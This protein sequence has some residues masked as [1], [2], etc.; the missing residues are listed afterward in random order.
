MGANLQPAHP[1][2]RILLTFLPCILTAQII[3]EPAHIQVFQTTAK[4]VHRGATVT[5]RWSATGAEQVRLEPLGLVLPAKGEITH[6]VTSRIVYWLHVT[7]GVGGQSVPLVVDLLPDEPALAVPAVPPVAPPDWPRLADLSP[8]PPSQAPALPP[9]PARRLARRRGPR[10]VWIQ[11]AATVSTKGAAKLKR[12]LKRLAATDSTLLVR[13][14][15]TGRP[16]QL[17]RSGPFHSLQAARL[18]LQEL[19]PAMQ[20]MKIKPIIIFGPPQPV[21][22]ETTYLADSRQPG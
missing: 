12:N 4:A 19:A 14:R 13:N 17:I 3:P 1:M 20:A 16:F 15:R 8:V 21:A 9:P 6:R 5:L 22:A 11:F 7:N 2:K 18:R 10:R